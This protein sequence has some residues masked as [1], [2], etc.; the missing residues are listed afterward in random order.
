M[1]ILQAVYGTFEPFNRLKVI[2]LMALDFSGAG[3]LA[4]PLVST[5]FSQADRWSFHYLCSFGIAFLN[6]ISLI[7]VFRFRN[8]EGTQYDFIS[9][10]SG[11]THLSWLLAPSVLGADWARTGGTWNQSRQPVQTDIQ[12]QSSSSHGIFHSCRCRRSG[13]YKQMRPT[14][15]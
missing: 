15:Q 14:P 8:Q 11:F 1:G 4:A 10:S 7:I 6:T 9:F 13:K 2:I 12:S 3:A 5:Q